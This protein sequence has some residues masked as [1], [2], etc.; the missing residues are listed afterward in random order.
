MRWACRLAG[1]LRG[2][3]VAVHAL[4]LMERL[5][6]ELVV[7]HRRRAEIEQLLER[8]W[9]AP[10]R[11]GEAGIRTL[12]REGYPADVLLAVAEEV[13]AGLV[14]VGNRGTGSAPALALG[15]TSLHVLRAAQAPVLVIPEGEAGTRHLALRRILV[16]VEPHGSAEAAVQITC[17]LAAVFGSWVTVLEAVDSLA[18][19][20]D[21]RMGAELR[22]RLDGCGVPAHVAVRHGRPDEVM[23]S[24]ANL[25]DAD[26]VVTG[27]RPDREHAAILEGSV[28]RQVARA[29]HRP[30]LVVPEG[31]PASPLGLGGRPDLAVAGGTRQ[32]GD[33]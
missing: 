32:V 6:G 4:G 21:D 29:A 18:D 5:E 2:E 20:L 33:V 16:G 19:T 1:V 22:L 13:N 25:I 9:C 24:V 12:V 31:W 14:V 3:V 30:A 26:L 27:R 17:G 15:S 28:S 10:A 23:R 11:P 7:A 8:E